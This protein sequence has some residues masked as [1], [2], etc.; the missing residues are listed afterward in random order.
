MTMMK[1]ELTIP[2]LFPIE[3][4]HIKFVTMKTRKPSGIARIIL[5]LVKSY[6]S[7]DEMFSD[8]L[9]RFGVPSELHYIFARELSDICATGILSFRDN[10]QFSSND[11][12]RCYIGEF[13]FSEFGQNV[14]K[15]GYITTNEERVSDIDVFYDRIKAKIT[16]SGRTFPLANTVY[17]SIKFEDVS[18][19]QFDFSLLFDEYREKLGLRK[20]EALKNGSLEEWHTEL[21]KVDNAVS[22]SFTNNTLEINFVYERYRDFLKKNL[23]AEMFAKMLLEKTEFKKG[24]YFST[25]IPTISTIPNIGDTIMSVPV[26]K[27]NNLWLMCSSGL[28]FVNCSYSVPRKFIKGKVISESAFNEAIDEL[29]QEATLVRIADGKVQ[30]AIVADVCFTNNIFTDTITLPMVIAIE[31]NSENSKRFIERVC[32]IIYS[33]DYSV[34]NASLIIDITK[35]LNDK[36]PQKEYVSKLLKADMIDEALGMLE[37]KDNDKS[38]LELFQTYFESKCSHI[39][40]EQV[41]DAHS[42]YNSLRKRIG[43]NDVKY[44]QMLMSGIGNKSE[45]EHIYFIFEKLKYQPN[46]ILPSINMVDVYMSQ[47][48]SGKIEI[49]YANSL[50]DR[51]EALSDHLNRL[52]MLS[53]V[54][55][56]IT[57]SVNEQFDENAFS[58]IFKS[59]RNEY[60]KINKYSM[61][62]SD[63][64]RVLNEYV[65]IFG[66]INEVIALEKAAR[67]NI[68]DIN[69]EYI[70]SCVKKSDFRTAVCDM[71]IRLEDELQEYYESSELSVYNMLDMFLEEEPDSKEMIDKMH[72]LRIVRNRMFHAK[73]KNIDYTKHDLD[74]WRNALF[75]FIGGLKNEQNSED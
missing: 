19:D 44:I 26:G 34:K 66:E 47:L 17:S 43:I 10:A 74:E 1:S 53:G 20:E 49:K 30:I 40:P 73:S 7:F 62:S 31:C 38:V 41:F 55:S 58:E 71:Y 59:F 69:Y 56:H 9:L 70:M 65:D 6:H 25:N 28:I 32:D 42:E 33:E 35:I 3:V 29:Y 21:I 4:C 18:D 12:E 48:I 16:P 23:N 2:F 27:V 8:T 24:D 15:M 37:S 45:Y 75:E 51:F 61:Y 36:A 63:S 54:D 11:F 22:L 72:K 5:E 50:S 14:Y 46:V 39:T 68:S 57:Y 67:K 13:S 52:K 64:F 60:D